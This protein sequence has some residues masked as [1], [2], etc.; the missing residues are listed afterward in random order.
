MEFTIREY[1]NYSEDEILRLYGS[2]GWSAY[3]DAPET[4]RRGFEKSLLTLGAYDGEKLIG[5]IRTVGD[6][7]TVVF[8]QDIL[9]LPEYQ[10]QGIGKALIS[11]ILSRYS[12]V[13]QIEL[14]TD[15]TEKTK[16]FY[17]AVGFS[18][19]SELGCVGFMRLGK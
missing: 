7:E 1:E 15:D 16:S 18:E 8:I 12:H 9:V 19:M 2:V 17:K 4:L 5:I 14:A 11:E 6:G 13:R 10:R 3:T